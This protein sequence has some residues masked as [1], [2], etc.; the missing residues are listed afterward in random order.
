MAESEEKKQDYFK[1]GLDFHNE[2]KY[3][4]AIE[5]YNKALKAYGLDKKTLVLLGNTYYMTKEFEKAEDSYK[6]ALSLDPNYAK[7]HY[8]MG[9]I[10]DEL[11]RHN[12]SIE[13]FK[14]AVELDA[15]FAPAYANLG[16]VY[17]SLNDLENAIINFHK[18][19]EIESDIEL[20]KEGLKDIPKYLVEKVTDREMRTNSDKLIREGIED[21]VKGDMDEARKKY[22]SALKVFP[23]S[24]AGLILFTLV[25]TPEKPPM[26]SK[27]NI[28]FLRLKTS[29]IIDSISP[30]V[31]EFLSMKLGNIVLDS[32]SLEAFFERFKEIVLKQKESEIDLLKINSMILFDEPQE[33]L[34]KAMELD[35]NG[36]VEAAKDVFE[37]V[38]KKAPYLVHAYYLY[39]ISL[40]TNGDENGAFMKYKEATDHGFDYLDEKNEGPIID[41]FSKRPGYEYL[42]EMDVISILRE[43]YDKTL[44]GEEISLHRFIKYQLSQKAE[45]KLKYGFEREESGESQEAINAYEDAINIDPE[46]PISHYVLGLAYESRGLEKEAM[47]EYEKTKGTDLKVMQIESSE[48]V[49]RIVENYLGLKTKD[50]HRV[51]T[52]LERYFEI[53]ADD[54]EH[55]LELL[56]FIEDLKIESISKIIK[57]YISTDVILGKKGEED[58]G[59]GGKVGKVVRDQ[60]DFGEDLDKED[61]KIKKSKAKSKIS[62][63]LLWKYKTQRSIRREASTKDGKNIL[64]GSENGI[65]YFIDENA[66]SP[67]RYETGASIVD[68]DISQDGKYGVYCNS[69][70]IFELIDCTKKG[71]SL[72]KKDLRKSGVNSVAIR[73]ERL[74]RLRRRRFTQLKENQMLTRLL[75]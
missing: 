12:E 9:I 15:D 73:A 61:D 39:G 32:K 71:K 40:E 64:A 30:E 34:S 46:N 20:A 10:Y 28:E 67:W 53:I 43:F 25:E 4:K 23:K 54:P 27:K 1:L 35:I 5:M 33:E 8:N 72:W 29:L 44:E 60:L 26:L 36:E 31:R 70:N 11:N 48:D 68:I 50:G 42:K 3:D 16:G 74:L 37:K 13:S 47:M 62:F 21:E 24:A 57:S 58:L 18:A 49:S 63:E 51:G 38:I 56:G 52:I 59:G 7:A 2:G 69:K 75:L 41:F 19:L 66:K 14:R 55:M 22:E 6:R 65:I 45:A 17:K